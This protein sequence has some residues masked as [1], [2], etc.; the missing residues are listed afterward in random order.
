MACSVPPVRTTSSTS[1]GVTNGPPPTFTTGG[2]NNLNFY[3]NPEM[4]K[5]TAALSV[6]FDI[7]RIEIQKEIDK[8]L[9]VT[10]ME[11]RS[12]SSRR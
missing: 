10:S 7:R 1:L 3:S 9:G 8:L 2:I 6:E 12:S 5:L 4:D 11:S